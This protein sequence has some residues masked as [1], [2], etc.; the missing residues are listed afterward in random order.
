M[1]NLAT[2]AAAVGRNKNAILRAIQNGKIPASRDANGEMQI[3]PADL[4]L[5]Y[6]PLRTGDTPQ[7][8]LYQSPL[9]MPV[10]G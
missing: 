6:P 5:I 8:R 7:Q 9:L 3:D 10:G 2:A 4:H 1:Y